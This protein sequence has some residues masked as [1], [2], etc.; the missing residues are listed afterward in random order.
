[1]KPLQSSPPSLTQ[2]LSEQAISWLPSAIRLDVFLW[3]CVRLHGDTVTD[4]ARLQRVLQRQ[5]TTQQQR[6]LRKCHVR[7]S[8]P[9]RL[10]ETVQLQKSFSSSSASVYWSKRTKR[11]WIHVDILCRFGQKWRERERQ[12]GSRLSLIRPEMRRSAQDLVLASGSESNTWDHMR[13]IY[14][15]SRS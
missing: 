10:H 8:S 14:G 7:A 11:S 4:R 1:M 3:G 9:E 15:L 2:H 13:P 12:R 5:A 6:V